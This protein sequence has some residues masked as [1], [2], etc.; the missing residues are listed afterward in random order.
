[1]D[2]PF[3]ITLSAL[4][5]YVAKSHLKISFALY[6][7]DMILTDDF[8]SKCVSNRF[9]HNPLANDEEKLGSDISNKAQGR[10]I[11]IIN[12][13]FEFMKN[14]ESLMIKNHGKKDYYLMLQVL[15]QSELEV[16]VDEEEEEDDDYETAM[17]YEL[18]GWCL[19]K[20]NNEEGELNN[21]KNKSC[22]NQ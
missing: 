3:Q 9:V 14:I 19:F 2:K 20:L 8:G 11:I 5:N 1:M 10:D 12:D 22:D 4:K 13:E 21:R 15:E 6:E 17:E 7:E 18:R 16:E